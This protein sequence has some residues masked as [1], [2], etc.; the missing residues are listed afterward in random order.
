M[1]ANIMEYGAYGD[2]KAIYERTDCLQGHQ[3]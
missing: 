2:E 3:G 1:M